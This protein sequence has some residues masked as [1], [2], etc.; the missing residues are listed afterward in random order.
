MTIKSMARSLAYRTIST[1]GP[2]KPART[3]HTLGLKVLL[4]VI[5]VSLRPLKNS[6]VR[7]ERNHQGLQN[8]LITG[9]SAIADFG[10]VRRRSR[11]G[12]LLHYY[13]RAA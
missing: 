11:L 4:L 12:G 10:R 7:G 8:R 13:E 5:V 6:L 3:Q 1:Y 2:P 9:A